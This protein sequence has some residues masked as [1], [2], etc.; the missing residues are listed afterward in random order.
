[1]PDAR[2]QNRREDFR[3]IDVLHMRDELL[4]QDEFESRR[5]Q[6]GMPSRISSTLRQMLPQSVDVDQ[7]LQHGEICNDL[8]RAIESLDNKLNYLI[9]VNMLNEAERHHLKERTVD[10]STTGMCFYSDEPYRPGQ[11]L[12]I[13]LVVPMAPP[14]MMALLAEIK[15]VRKEKG[16]PRIG[17][18]FRFRSMEER[19][20]VARYVF[21]RH[22]EMIRLQDED[23]DI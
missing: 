17:I 10:I 21:R 6:M 23:D 8:V 11:F 12:Q 18:S 4:S 3:I 19:D 9:T 20:G 7:L 5:Q 15:W 2:K 13:E 22:R 16:R 1:M 14:Q